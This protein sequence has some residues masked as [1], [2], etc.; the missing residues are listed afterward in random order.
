MVLLASAPYVEA[1]IHNVAI[2][3]PHPPHAFLAY[4]WE[5]SQIFYCTPGPRLSTNVGSSKIWQDRRPREDD[6]TLCVVLILPYLIALVVNST[7]FLTH[8]TYPCTMISVNIYTHLSRDAFIELQKSAN[9]Q[10]RHWYTLYTIQIGH[11]KYEGP[12]SHVSC[13]VSH[14][15]T[16]LLFYYFTILLFYYFTILLF[17]YFTISFI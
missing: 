12:E 8:T 5:I 4:L 13:L 10:K 16:I 6:Q 1:R 7:K 14:Y 3:H 9:H 2:S 15:F 17:Y 11:L